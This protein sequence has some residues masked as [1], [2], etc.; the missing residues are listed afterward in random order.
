MKQLGWM[1]GYTHQFTDA[2]RGNLVVS[3]TEFSSNSDVAALAAATD[4]TNGILMKTGYFA[5]AN[6][7]VM[8]SKNLQ[9]GAEYVWEQAKAFG[10]NNALDRL[11]RQPDQQ[12][13]QQ[14]DRAGPQGQ[15]LVP[16]PYRRAGLMILS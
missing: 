16:P 10:S 2:V 5:A 8:L 3:G 6:V 13:R 15:L 1:V 12:D 9:F 7:F 4:S 11:R 14:Q